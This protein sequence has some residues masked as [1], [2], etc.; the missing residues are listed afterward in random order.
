MHTLYAIKPDVSHQQ[1]PRPA[2]ADVRVIAVEQYGAGPWGSMQLA[3]LGADVIKLEDPAVDGDV[4][5][6]VP[7][8]QD[9]E[10]SL[11]FES[12]NRNKRSISL[13]LR[14]PAGR[15]AFRRL[16]ANVDAVF[17]N[18]R[19][20][21]PERLGLTYEQLRDV[22][23]AIVCCSLSGYGMTGPRAAHG[24]Y[25]YVIQGLAGWMSL[26]GDPDGPPAKSGLSLVDFGGGYVAALALMGGLWRAR[27]DGVGC[28]C[29][30]SLHETALSLLSYVGTWAA[31]EG[32][33]PQRLAES[34]HPSIVPFQVFATGDGWIVVACPKDKFWRALC[35]AL[36]VP[37]LAF[38]ERFLTMAARLEHRD[39]LLA[40]LRPR[41]AARS[42]DE[43]LALL[44]AASV[45]CAP[46]NDVEQA[47]ADEQV[48]ARE[49]IVEFEHPR[50]G[51]VRQVASPL[52]VDDGYR[53]ARPGPA[54]GEHT[55]AVLRE[56]GGFSEAEVVEL[57]AVGALGAEPVTPASAG[58][59]P[60]GPEAAA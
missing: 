41:F 33:R 30:V 37:E 20:D 36:G 58:A 38:E 53:T 25:D 13:D 29:D 16:V 4:G 9:G 22:N 12:F 11:F 57:A 52:R 31:T 43:L 46:V 59:E 2:L 19:G 10:D 42:T 50:L 60:V 34:A 40:E 3:D 32:Y 44:T 55:T 39:E 28:Q 15:A 14:A 27:R 51:S 56:L 26:T 45:P 47:L 5:R 49:A 17:C 48:R 24:A 8:F 7:P 35:A 21:Q 1:Q 6:Y 54:R 23:P 18:L